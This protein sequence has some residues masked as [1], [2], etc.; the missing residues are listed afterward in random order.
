MSKWRKTLEYMFKD[1]PKSETQFILSRVLG[2][3]GNLVDRTS[4]T[5]SNEDLRV[6]RPIPD[7]W[8]EK[9]LNDIITDRGN[10]IFDT[11]DNPI[12]MWS[13]GIDSTVVFY[14]MLAIGKPFTV[15]YNNSSVKEYPLLATQLE[16]G[17]PNVTAVFHSDSFKISDYILAHPEARFVTG[18][19]GD[20]TF[21]SASIFHFAEVYRAMPIEEVVALDVVP[22]EVYEYTVPS[23]L[24]ALKIT[25]METITLQAY[26]WAINFI[27]KY[28]HVQLRTGIMRF[29]MYSETEQ[30]NTLH[31]FDTNDFNSYAL[32]NYVVN[33]AF[34]KETDYKMPLKE[35]IF[36][37]NGDEEYLKNKTKVESLS[38][39]EY[40]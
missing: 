38:Y 10:E 13:G 24:H 11:F 32:I 4:I 30:N 22:R 3:N 37:Q 19:L 2:A 1:M 26:L 25:S 29:R 27:F 35:Y 18:E 15:Y 21:G 16:Q 36:S 23:I 31:F 33:S 28:Q 6:C 40:N 5:D 14:S 8:V 9:D 12:L 39:R 17:I 20:Q 34:V 7:V